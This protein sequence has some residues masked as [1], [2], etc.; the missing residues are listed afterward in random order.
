VLTAA[1]G[2]TALATYLQKGSPID[3]VILDLIMPGMGGR[4]CLSKLLE[5]NPQAKIIVCSGHFTEAESISPIELGARGFIRKP[6]ELSEML[7]C[8]RQVLDQK[9]KGF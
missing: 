4:Q 3:L 1:E 2:E 5:M 6:Y 7:D 9:G 8:V